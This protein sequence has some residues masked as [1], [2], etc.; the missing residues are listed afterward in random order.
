MKTCSKDVLMVNQ[1]DPANP[2]HVAYA[3]AFNDAAPII[4]E[5][6]DRHGLAQICNVMITFAVNLPLSNPALIAGAIRGFEDGL[7][8]LQSE[9][10]GPGGRA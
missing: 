4:G 1:L 5:M 2:H 6:I 8:V 7:L 9:A 10:H 3:A